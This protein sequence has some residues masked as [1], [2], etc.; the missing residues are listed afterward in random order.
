MQMQTHT[1]PLQPC[2]LPDERLVMLE[3]VDFKWLMAG[4]GWWIDTARLHSD[5]SYAT[6]L[7]DLVEA[8]QSV[9]LKDCAA[10]LRAQVGIRH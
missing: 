3:E 2:Q 6:H 8:T 9:A 1:T 5:P 4:Q 10:L 7:L